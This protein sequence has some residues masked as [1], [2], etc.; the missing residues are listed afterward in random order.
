MTI[1][2]RTFSAA[3]LRRPAASHWGTRPVQAP[4]HTEAAADGGSAGIT[5]APWEG[6][7]VEVEATQD[8]AAASALP[9]DSELERFLASLMYGD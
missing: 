1:V 6:L 3:F 2:P 9:A 5:A 7:Y 4:A 8:G